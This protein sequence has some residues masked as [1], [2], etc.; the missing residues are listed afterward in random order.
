MEKIITEYFEKCIS[1]LDLTNSIV[2]LK[3]FN[4]IQ[5]PNINL[6]DLF[7]TKQ[8]KTW[9]NLFQS[10]RK[11]I[12]YEE[13]L[14]LYNFIE[15]EFDNIYIINNN[16][17]DNFYPLNV[18]IPADIKINLIDFYNQ[19]TIQASSDIEIFNG[20]EY[21]KIYSNITLLKNKIYVR[22][23]D[24]NEENCTKI[25]K[26]NLFNLT[27][28]SEISFSNTQ[29]I[30]K[31]NIIKLQEEIDY[32]LVLD[33]LLTNNTLY[34][35]K[36]DYIGEDNFL[37]EKLSLINTYIKPVY[38]VERKA[39]ETH[40]EHN[41]KIYNLL[42]QYWGYEHFRDLKVYDFQALKD[43]KKFVKSVSQE[44]IIND[45]LFQAE[46]I[47]NDHSYDY[48][49]IFVTAPTGAGKS[50][51]FLLPAMYL[52]EKYNL[53]TLV[54]SPLIGL[55]NDQVENI[56]KTSYKYA[57]TINSDL[58]QVQKEEI[59]DDIHNGECHILYLSPESLLARG[60]I[61]RLIGDR[62]IGMVVID[63][64][65][66]VTT[67]GK[68]FRPDYWYLGD[69]IKKLRKIQSQES[70]PFIL[71]TFTATAIY[72][73]I[74]D[75]YKETLQSLSMHSPITY[76]GY[77]K[78]NDITI[79]I[80]EQETKKHREEYELNK[81]DKLI[82]II[83][84][85]IFMDKKT[86]I[87]FPTVRLIYSFYN[88]CLSKNL[89]KYITIYNGQMPA[90][91]KKENAEL[92]KN[93]EKLIMLATKAFGMGIDISD[94]EIVSHFAPTGNVCDYVQ[95]I[96]R[97]A[98]KKEL[99]GEA[100][101]YHMKND[102]QHI[103]K[104]HGLSVVKRYQLIQ[105]IQKIFELFK[106]HIQQEEMN[107]SNH[108][109]KKR[110][111]LLID[112]NNFTYI[113]EGPMESSED[114]LIAKVK[115]A[116]LLIQ[117]DY[118]QQK[119]YSPFVMR[120]VNLYTKGY[121]QIPDE[122]IDGLMK[123]Y[124]NN[125]F[126]Y[127]TNSEQVYLV[128]LEHI[129]KKSYERNISFPMFKF[130]VYSNDEKVAF[131]G[132]NKLISAVC[133]KLKYSED[134]TSSILL[135]SIFSILKRSANNDIALTLE[136]NDNIKQKDRNIASYLQCQ[137][138][139]RKFKANSIANILISTIKTYNRNYNR[140]MNS[141]LYKEVYSKGEV[142]SYFFFRPIYD[143]T[144][145]I[146]KIKKYIQT[147]EKDGILYL[148][149]KKNDSTMKETITVLGFLESIGYLTF[150][151]NGGLN[152]QIYIHIT[153]TKTMQVVI[154]NPNSYKNKLLEKV[155]ERHKTSVAMLSFLFQQDFSSNEIWEYIENYFLG[156]IPEE[157]KTSL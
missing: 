65:H 107:N 89:S 147:N 84:R 51:M 14:Y 31:N 156:I 15:Q 103:N 24:E 143:F 114:D 38:I 97:A 95:E 35:D 61:S 78:R 42:K 108:F 141:A 101:Y 105:V 112:A 27:N 102:F 32:L 50:L 21:T 1:N 87:Y 53:V 6:Q 128:N 67:W 157:V 119:A 153:E 132:M 135:N 144:D 17:C 28:A 82:E 151:A 52:A 145:W 134:R 63:E 3:G 122:I 23:N 22:Y 44:D 85:S 126:Q 75:M 148:V 39:L 121:F 133:V 96:G 110:N 2:V 54:I 138:K 9:L 142:S 81:Y 5:L 60:D 98:R 66:I 11:Y 30:S 93:K 29:N 46:A 152:S 139:I 91:E 136:A 59:I 36:E 40:R 57:K 80:Q 18:N 149:N 20:E 123:Y 124:G 45:I 86:L 109:S 83:Q 58:S 111:D 62:K 77:V 68:Q 92:F 69:Y 49:D 55:M 155:L 118:F 88:Y 43:G 47:M 37:N 90:D 4:N 41:Q 76:L 99:Q 64:A 125:T 113:F 26:I 56:E 140:A 115:T 48:K 8:T 71:T 16:I 117:K 120:P 137:A 25:K 154:N 100:V 127:C 116:M 150:E 73:G 12:L 146:L 70:H 130:L 13:F 34:I 33:N 19:E 79:K 104:L 10:G 94:I 129:W 74:E 106:I 72:G 131:M 7:N